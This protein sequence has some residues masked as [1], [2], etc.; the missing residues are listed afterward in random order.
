MPIG[1]ALGFAQSHNHFCKGITNHFVLLNSDSSISIFTSI[2][3]NIHEL[4]LYL[5]DTMEGK[6][7]YDN[8]AT[9]DNKEVIGYSYLQTVAEN[10]KGFT[11]RQI[12]AADKVHQLY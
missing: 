5:H 3:D 12:D 10:K 8:T 11:K 1:S 6:T 2:L 4:G 7:A 9:N